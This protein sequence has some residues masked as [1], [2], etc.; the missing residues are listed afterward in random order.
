MSITIL[1]AYICTSAA[2]DSCSVWEEK[3]WSGP[4]ASVYCTAERDL[5]QATSLPNQ[6]IRFEC[7]DFETNEVVVHSF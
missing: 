7:E 6:F 3:R 1:L 5:A 4:A 2:M